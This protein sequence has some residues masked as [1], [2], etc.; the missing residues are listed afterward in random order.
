MT[1]HKSFGG[2]GRKPVQGNVQVVNQ[3]DVEAFAGM[4]VKT[5]AAWVVFTTTHGSSS[6]RPVSYAGGG[7]AALH[8]PPQA[9]R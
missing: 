4:A 1:P 6:S 5:G 7:V 8:L 3:F 9:Y 2:F